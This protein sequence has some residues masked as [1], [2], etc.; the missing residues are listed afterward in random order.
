MEEESI[1]ELNKGVMNSNMN[2]G[3]NTKGPNTETPCFWVHNQNN[4]SPF[5]DMTLILGYSFLY[6]KVKALGESRYCAH[7]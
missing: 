3:N 7:C 1:E 4:T 5:Y 2:E 6:T